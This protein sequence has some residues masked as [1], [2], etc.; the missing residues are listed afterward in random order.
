MG[1]THTINILLADDDKYD[2][3]FF[4]DVLAGLPLSTSLIIVNHGEQLMDHL[5]KL[6]TN[7]PHALFLDLNMPRK[8]GFECLKEIRKQSFLKKLFRKIN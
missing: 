7:L 5:S 2:C 1:P 8:N 3:L 4:K 6:S